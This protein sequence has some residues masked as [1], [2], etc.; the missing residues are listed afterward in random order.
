MQTTPVDVSMAGRLIPPVNFGYVEEDL[1]R[2]GEPSALNL[3]FLSQLG[4]KK[5][6]YLAPETPSDD[7]QNFAS[8]QGIELVHLGA[9]ISS[10]LWEPITE[11]LVLLALEHTLDRNSYPLAVMCKLGRHRTGVVVG[12]LRKLQRWNLTSILEEY[13]RFAGGK[14]RLENEQFIELFDT[15]LVPIPP[16]R[17]KWL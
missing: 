10:N 4:L 5:I 9:R 2:S 14:P 17:P 7:F 11:E 6:V 15:D 8:D 16:D 12:C 1:V 3:L 13:R